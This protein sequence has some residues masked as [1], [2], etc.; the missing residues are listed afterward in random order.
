M[1]CTVVEN[2]TGVKTNDQLAIHC[3]VKS[4]KMIIF[5]FSPTTRTESTGLRFIFD[6]EGVPLRQ[7]VR[8]GSFPH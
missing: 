8:G 3:R 5:A 6:A 7:W 4:A 1:L 2:R